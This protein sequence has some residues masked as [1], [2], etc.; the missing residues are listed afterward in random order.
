[1]TIPTFQNRTAFKQGVAILQYFINKYQFS[2][3]SFFHNPLM[4]LPAASGR[5]STNDATNLIAASDG[6]LDPTLCNKR[7]QTMVTFNIA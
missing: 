4:N 3:S 5:V 6:A 7:I 2:V 1:M